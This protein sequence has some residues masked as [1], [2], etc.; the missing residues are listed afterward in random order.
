MLEVPL[1]LPA[2]HRPSIDKAPRPWRSVRKTRVAMISRV[3]AKRT[4]DGG[5][6]FRN[7][8]KNADHFSTYPPTHGRDSHDVRK[9]IHNNCIAKRQGRASSLSLAGGRKTIEDALLSP[10]L[11]HGYPYSD[12]EVVFHFSVLL[13]AHH[14]RKKDSE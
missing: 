5:F 14:R 2:I 9:A 12:L 10:Q 4:R 1:Q 8:S 13:P 6:P 7:A 11:F 3:M